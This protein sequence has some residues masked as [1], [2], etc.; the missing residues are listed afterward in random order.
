MTR[1]TLY[2]VI[3]LLLLAAALVPLG[4]CTPEEETQD[5]STPAEQE[6]AEQEADDTADSSDE[7]AEQPA[8]ALAWTD[9]ELTDVETGETFTISEFTDGPVLIQAFAVW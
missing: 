2:S 9:I 4:A 1:N 7:P 3:L 5:E 6:P 8:S